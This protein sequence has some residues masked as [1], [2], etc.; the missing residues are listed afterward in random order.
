M[1][2]AP[3]GVRC[4]LA[5]CLLTTAAQVWTPDAFAQTPAVVVEL[6]GDRWLIVEAKELEAIRTAVIAVPS[7]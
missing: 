7:G 1:R 2:R 4:A 5:L 6:D 3:L